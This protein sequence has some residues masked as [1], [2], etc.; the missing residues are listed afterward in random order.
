MR[1]KNLN[2]H[3]PFNFIAAAVGGKRRY[4]VPS[5]APPESYYQLRALIYSPQT[6]WNIL[7]YG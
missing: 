4:E 7:D 1:E 5:S 3:R 2:A 6:Y